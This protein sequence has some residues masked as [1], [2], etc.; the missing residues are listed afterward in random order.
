MLDD[1]L[2]RAVLSTRIAPF[3]DD[4]YLMAVLDN[5]FLNLNEL[6]L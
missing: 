5:V 6:D 3:E 4:K 2:D 1:A